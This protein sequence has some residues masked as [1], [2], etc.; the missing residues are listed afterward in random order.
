MVVVLKFSALFNTVD[1]PPFY[2]LVGVMVSF[3]CQFGWDIVSITQSH[4]NLGV[5]VKM[6]VKSEIE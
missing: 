5:F 3:M 1:L 2:S 6:Q 4:T